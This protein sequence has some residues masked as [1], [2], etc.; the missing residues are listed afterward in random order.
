M[1]V[2][3]IL[4]VKGHHVWSVGPD[5]PVFD[6]LALMAKEN[7]G[8][9]V[10]M[11][12]DELLGIFSERDYARKVVLSGRSSRETPVGRIMTSAV[13][14]IEPGQSVGDCM[15]LMTQ[16]R[17]RHLP[18]VEGKKMVGLISIGD[19]VKAVISEQKETIANLETYIRGKA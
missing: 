3:H 18:V 17:V 2:E 1:T 5:V 9:L 7:I 14:T 19:V 8:A 13:V 12:G 10:V 11:S 15:T 6:A 16:N 4:Q